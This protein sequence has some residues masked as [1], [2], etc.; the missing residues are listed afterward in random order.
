MSPIGCSA[1]LQECRH[2]NRCE[3]IHLPD[4]TASQ[5][6]RRIP[7]IARIRQMQCQAHRSQAHLPRLACL[8]LPT[9]LS[10]SSCRFDDRSAS[11]RNC[12]HQAVA[13]VGRYPAPPACRSIRS[14]PR[15]RSIAH[16]CRRCNWAAA[17]PNPTNRRY[18]RRRYG[19]RKCRCPNDQ[20][21]RQI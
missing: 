21:M 8:P 1:L 2:R 3:T 6:G 14:L 4:A 10:K 19:P 9:C 12:F 15:N 17:L 13:A 11:P 5:L 18:D 20:I 16:C 7:P